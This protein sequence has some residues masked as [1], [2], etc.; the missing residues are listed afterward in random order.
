MGLEFFF[1]DGDWNQNRGHSAA[2]SG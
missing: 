2:E 1:A